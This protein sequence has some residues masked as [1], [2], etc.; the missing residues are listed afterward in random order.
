M[1]HVADGKPNVVARFFG[2]IGAFI[3]G[4]F[5]VLYLISLLGGISSTYMGLFSKFIFIGFVLFIIGLIT[6]PL[7]VYIT[8]NN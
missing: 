1:G 7:N 8:K 5:G 4:L 2:N 3:A 6:I